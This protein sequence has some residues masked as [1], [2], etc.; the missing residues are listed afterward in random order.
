M[1]P[2]L[3]F[4]DKI[5]ESVIGKVTLLWFPEPPLSDK[6]AQDPFFQITVSER[7]KIAI[8]L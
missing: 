1:E 5:A 4:L 7:Q 2:R 3:V 6:Q 8:R